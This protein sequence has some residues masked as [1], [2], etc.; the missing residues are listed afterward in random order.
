[1]ALYFYLTEVGSDVVFSGTGT[2]NTASLGSAVAFTGPSIINAGLAEL[3][4]KP[5][6]NGIQYAG[7]SGPSNFG[8]GGVSPAPDISSGDLVGVSG[9]FGNIYLPSAYTSGTQLDSFAS[10]TAE[11]FSSL[12]ITSGTYTYTWGTGGSADSLVLQVG[13]AVTPTPTVTPT[14][15][16]TPTVTPT[17]TVTPTVSPSGGLSPTPTSTPTK[18]PTPTPS[19][20][21][22]PLPLAYYYAIPC[23]S[24]NLIRIKT[25]DS[26]LIIEGQVN[27]LNIGGD[28]DCYTMLSTGAGEA[29]S[30]SV[31][32][33]PWIDCVS[34]YGNVTPTPT[35]TVT[36]T[37]TATPTIT[38]TK[39][40][41]P[42]VTPTK[43]VTPTVT[44]TVTPTQTKTPTVTPSP[45]V[46]A[47]VTPSISVSA[48][49]T[50][51]P[52]VTPTITVSPTNSPLP[53]QYYLATACNGGGVFLVK[54]YDSDQIILGQ[55]SKLDISGNIDCYTMSAGYTDPLA[56]YASVVN[57]P[58]ISCLICDTGATRTP[59]P[60]KT[61]TPTVTPSVTPTKTSTQT[62]TQTPTL[63]PTKTPTPSIT[64]SVT[65]TK[66][67]TQTPTPTSTVTPTVT[68]SISVSATKTPT[69]TATVT[70]T[71]TVTPTKT[72]TPSITTS[73][74][75]TPTIFGTLDVD[76][77]YE[78]GPGQIGSFS[79]GTYNEG[80]FGP[81]PHPVAWNP[82]PGSRAGNVV[83]L[84]AIKIGSDG[85]NN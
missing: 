7:I 33:G 60:T 28:I 65:P 1:M 85:L 44:Q 70:K 83:D 9:F 69:P 79:G 21:S 11:T 8:P 15:T 30:A 38:P 10:F 59:T 17:K 46:T 18:T 50:P 62:P 19:I 34:C 77:Q 51:T 67:S 78:Y 27:R 24:S 80:L 12:G 42:T 63:T 71:P 39:T 2:V 61:P 47:T 72:V 52:T 81:V 35:R 66:T 82:Q 53:I 48:T 16:V 13:P 54:S 45:T 4:N 23:G 6:S 49:K 43:T 41:T 73:V 25:H 56:Q 68:P 75:P 40:A 58:W 36:P 3:I 20:S 76:V 64:T 22:S 32:T 29:Q 26:D 5:G 84:S 57:G 31:V 37:S 55:V 74:T 14:K